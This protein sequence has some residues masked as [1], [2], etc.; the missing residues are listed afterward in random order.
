MKT[1]PRFL[2]IIRKDSWR[3]KYRSTNEKG[4]ID[5]I[6]KSSYSITNTQEQTTNQTTLFGTQQHRDTR[7]ELNQ[8]DG[9][10]SQVHE[11]EAM[12]LLM[13]NLGLQRIF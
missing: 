5:P 6:L 3:R 13:N 2:E 9:L 10:Y 8:L 1:K 12:Q 11:S 4:T 7:K